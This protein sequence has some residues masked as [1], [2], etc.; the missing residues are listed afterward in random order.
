[1]SEMG[2]IATQIALVL[3]VLALSYFLLVRPQLKRMSAHHA[4]LA[5]LTVGDRVVTRGGLIGNIA[6]FE[7]EDIVSLA[8]S[9]D[10]VVS[11]ERNAIERRVDSS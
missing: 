1:M 6:A 2:R 7:G 4:F 8:L 11:L 10:M 3:S 5:A 9:D